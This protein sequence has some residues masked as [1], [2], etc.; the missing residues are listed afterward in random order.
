MK[1]KIDEDIDLD[2]EIE[3]EEDDKKKVGVLFKLEEIVPDSTNYKMISPKFVPQ[4]P[5]YIRME[6]E[7]DEIIEETEEIRIVTQ[8]G[9]LKMMLRYAKLSKDYERGI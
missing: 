4:I 1:L 6:I 5:T 8:E 3:L 9:F 2:E 7:E